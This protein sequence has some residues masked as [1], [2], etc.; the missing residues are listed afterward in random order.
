VVLYGHQ[1]IVF[2]LG[3]KRDASGI[4]IGFSASPTHP[5]DSTVATGGAGTRKGPYFDSFTADRL[6]YFPF[7]TGGTTTTNSN[8]FPSFLD[9]YGTQPYLYFTSQKAGNDYNAIAQ[10]GVMPYQLTSTRYVNPNG[11]Q[12]ISAG[13][14]Q[15]FNAGGLN[16]PGGGGSVTTPDGY[17]NMANFHPTL[18]GI[19]NN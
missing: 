13:K 5:M 9:I 4:P 14:N 12:I 17:Y 16:W 19:A 15:V 2:F 18:L 1:T 8:L 3:G 6:Q 10:M 7:N 11:I